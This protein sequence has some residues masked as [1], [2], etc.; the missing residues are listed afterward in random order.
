MQSFHCLFCHGYEERG[1]FSSGIL[2]VQE[3]AFLPTTL[4]MA[5][6]ALQL[7]NSVTIYTHGDEKLQRELQA[8]VASKAAITFN[9]RVIKGFS[10]PDDNSRIILIFEDG[11]TKEEAFIATKPNCV[12]RNKKLSEDLGLE[13]T[14]QGDIKCT[15]PLGETSITGCFSAGDCWYQFKSIPGAIHGGSNAAAGASSHVQSRLYGH[16][17]LGDYL[18]LLEQG[19]KLV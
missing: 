5:Q 19:K 1:D 11:S 18:K 15:P 16:K 14:P 8:A 2:A 12:L 13:L 6:N 7:T 17:S 9:S 4:H 10:M 3:A